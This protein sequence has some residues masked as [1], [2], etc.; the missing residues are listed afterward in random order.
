[1]ESIIENDTKKKIKTE[2]EPKTGSVGVRAT[3]NKMGFTDTQ[4]GYDDLSKTVTLNGRALL[5]PTY[6]DEAE[7]R[8]YAPESDIQKSVVD[9][10]KDTRNP[11]VKVSDAYASAAGRYGLGS[12]ALSYSNDTVT[13]GGKPLNI[14][15][16]DESGKAWARLDD[17]NALAQSYAKSVG[18]SDPVAVHQD[19]EDKLYSDIAGA[20]ERLNNRKEFSY[21]IDN[22]PVYKAYESRYLLEADRAS[23]DAL[24]DYSAMTG[25]YVNS[26]AVTAGALANQYYASKLADVIPTL[27]EQA[28]QRYYDSYQ[29]DLDLI[30]RAIALY[31][32]TYS[33]ASDAYRQKNENI[34]SSARSSVERD[35]RAKA[36]EQ[37][38]YERYWNELFNTQKY[39]QSETE[40]YWNELLYPIEYEAS[41]LKNQG[42]G[43][44]NDKQ[45]I[46]NEYYRQLLE[47]ELE[48]KE[49]DNQKTSLD[50]SKLLSSLR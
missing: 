11:V 13:I 40:N 2:T 38:R 23:R 42:I 34:N 6:I 44:D 46:Y 9:F 4:I 12:D 14:L 25:G 41:V 50:I 37:A 39:N 20:V 28:Y 33:N 18:A 43:L 1:M 10:Y 31:D 22:D 17:V 26:S 29:T 8:A 45:N 27:Y 21:D 49:L 7:G 48:G 47:T 5:K 30:D 15:Y 35:E 24:A 36:D 3:L 19:Y 16:T 32:E